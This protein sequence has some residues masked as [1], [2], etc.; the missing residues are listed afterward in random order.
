[1]L[2][3]QICSGAQESCTCLGLAVALATKQGG[4]DGLALTQDV[5]ESVGETFLRVLTHCR[6][7]V[8]RWSVLCSLFHVDPLQR[9]TVACSQEN[10]SKI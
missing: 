9:S 10:D 2:H 4:D 7:R 5:I 6:H 3:Q 8:C 1:M